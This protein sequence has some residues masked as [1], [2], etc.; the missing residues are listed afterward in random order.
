MLLIGL[1]LFDLDSYFATMQQDKMAELRR[2]AFMLGAKRCKLEVTEYE[3]LGEVA[4][5]GKCQGGKEGLGSN[6]RFLERFNEKR[7][8][9][10][11]Y[12]G[13]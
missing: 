8:E 6:R 12:T 10:S 2:I 4:R 1:A 9:N 3:E 13:I 5:L 11:V 7:E